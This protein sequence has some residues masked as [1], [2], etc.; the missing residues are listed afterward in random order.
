[1]DEKVAL[2]DEIRQIG[3]VLE[4]CRK[5]SIDPSM[6]YRWKESFDDLGIEGLR[7]RSG[8]IEPG[9]RK[10]KKENERL[11]GI[12]AEEDLEN[13]MLQDAFKFEFR[14]EF[15]RKCM[16]I[17]YSSKPVVHVTGFLSLH[18]PPSQDSLYSSL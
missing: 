6:L 13:A 2:I 7:T 10:L 11:K 8:K 1:M 15:L 16:L 14:L 5:Y 4:T 18:Q 3:Y 17:L 9:I 12:V